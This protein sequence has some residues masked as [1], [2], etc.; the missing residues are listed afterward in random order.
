MEE[1]TIAN[2]IYHS[3]TYQRIVAL[4]EGRLVAKQAKQYLEVID[5]SKEKKCYVVA[6]NESET[7]Q[8]KNSKGK[9]ICSCSSRRVLGHCSHMLALKM[10]LKIWNHNRRMQKELFPEEEVD[11]ET[12][13][14]VKELLKG[15]I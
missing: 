11:I 4:P 6:P 9:F 1:M 3:K 10:M 8:I 2:V 15:G 7:Y 14:K 5:Y 12:A 13:K